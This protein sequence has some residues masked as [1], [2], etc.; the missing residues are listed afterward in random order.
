M[1]IKYNTRTK[2]RKNKQQT[3]LM[4]R[5]LPFFS[6]MKK[7]PFVL[8]L[9]CSESPSFLNLVISFSISV[10]F[11]LENKSNVEVLRK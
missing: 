4:T 10:F 6:K 5:L 3:N 1:Q 7:V 8:V 9:I 2:T 11:F